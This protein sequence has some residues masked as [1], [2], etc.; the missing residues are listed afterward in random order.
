[1]KIDLQADEVRLL[2][3]WAGNAI[4][5]GHWG[6]GDMMLGEES[7]VFK[8]ISTSSEESYD[9]NA[10]E[11]RVL[12]YWMDT[13]VRD[14]KQRMSSDTSHRLSEKIKNLNYQE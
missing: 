4:A 9:F 7:V 11:I 5:G 12:K 1:M 14:S 8:K 10:L 2:K 3:I 13:N 6:D